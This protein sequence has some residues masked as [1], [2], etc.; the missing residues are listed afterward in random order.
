MWT[1]PTVVTSSKLPFLPFL[2]FTSN[3]LPSSVR[4]LPL[5]QV[6]C[7]VV[8]RVGNKRGY[9]TSSAVSLSCPQCAWFLDPGGSHTTCEELTE[10]FNILSDCAKKLKSYGPSLSPARLFNPRSSVSI[11]VSC[12]S[13]LGID[14]VQSTRTGT[15]LVTSVACDPFTGLDLRLTNTITTVPL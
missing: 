9:S 10:P 5:Y 2:P 1:S 3:F 6:V 12:P 8:I 15:E 14:P 4:S 11:F 13:S 7:V